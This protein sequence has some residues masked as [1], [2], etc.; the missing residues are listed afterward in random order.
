MNNDCNST[1]GS[2]SGLRILDLTRVWAGPLATRILGDFG[3]EI[4][5]IG[6]P[7]RPINTSSG[8]SN[9]LNRNKLN[10][11]LRLDVTAGREI[12]L[13]LV[14][15]S[16]VVIENFRPR[17]MSN[18]HLSYQDIR[19]VNPDIVMCSMPGF[20]TG[21]PYTEYPAFG[22]TAEALAGIPS[23][24]GY[25][26]QS[27]MPTGIAYADPISGL[28]AVGVLLACLRQRDIW[29]GGQFID[30]ALAASPVCTIGE[31]FVS[32]SVTQTNPLVKGNRHPEQTPHRAYQT[33]GDDEWIAISV[34]NDDE[35]RTLCFVIGDDAL[36]DPLYSTLGGRQAEEDYIDRRISEWAQEHS[37]LDIM[38]LL[39]DSGIPAGRVA[40]NR[41]LLDDV[42]LSARNFF[43]QLE[44]YSYGSKWYEGQS[45][46]GHHVE[47]TR[48]QPAHHFGQDGRHILVD[49]LGYTD[50]TC[51]T[52]AS[53]G[54]V[55]FGD[56]LQIER[57]EEE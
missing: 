53:D 42:H 24:M 55:V 1:K 54:T 41:Q 3:A 32:N 37:A 19:S 28:N 52:L 46:P 10:L 17:V 14:K 48:W 35:W 9:K 5:K 38:N 7:R 50:E 6:D 30:I 49:F 18:L 47:K 23:L 21:G 11:A 45:I 4:I 13:D 20:G 36:R 29:G 51:R 12:F 22:T 2:L 56:D 39:Q 34:T 8:V 44:E 16:D 33:A 40:N 31:Y 57:K 43:V 25:G 15:I 26:P 27:P